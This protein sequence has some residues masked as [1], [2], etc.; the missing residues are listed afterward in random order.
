MQSL[1]VVKC[2]RQHR[3]GFSCF[4]LH[5]VCHDD[6]SVGKCCVLMMPNK[7]YEG[8]LVETVHVCRQKML[9]RLWNVELAK[10]WWR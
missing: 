8:K 1:D 6:I 10:I 4:D 5:F 3:H 7:H 9:R 2:D